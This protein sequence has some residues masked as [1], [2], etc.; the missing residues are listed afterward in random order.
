MNHIKAFI[1]K[2]KN[3]FRHNL[4]QLF[5]I[6]GSILTIFI[7]CLFNWSYDHNFYD[8]IFLQFF[9]AIFCGLLSSSIL[10][11]LAIHISNQLSLFRNQLI[12]NFIVYM[13]LPFYLLW[14]FPFHIHIKGI[15]SINRYLLMFILLSYILMALI[16]IFLK[17]STLWQRILNLILS[18][19]KKEV[20]L[21]KRQ[22]I[23][24]LIISCSILTLLIISQLNWAY[25]H[26]FYDDIFIRLLFASIA[27][28]ISSALFISLALHLIKKIST[29]NDKK[30]LK[31]LSFAHIPLYLFL[32]YPFHIKIPA[33]GFINRYLAVM[34][35]IAYFLLWMIF[36]YM[37]FYFIKIFFTL[38]SSIKC[39]I[40]VGTSYSCSLGFCPK[41]FL[42]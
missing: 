28:L 10:I 40:P 42:K 32:L 30:I 33:V 18:T 2:E 39:P 13:H 36:L 3:Q 35:F 29:F 4:I 19:A 8:D 14:L 25:D 38:K 6:T 15:G 41:I 26:N 24:L 20:E 23:T 11:S 1:K 22:S 12:L 17:T 7:I 27:G 37:I 34:I 21:L 5:I 9:I 31:Y 16:I